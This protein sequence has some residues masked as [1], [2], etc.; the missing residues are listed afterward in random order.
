MEI[1]E[2]H[3]RRVPNAATS[4]V[5]ICRTGWGTNQNRNANGV[6]RARRNS[7]R[8]SPFHGHFFPYAIP[9]LCMGRQEGSKQARKGR[10]ERKQARKKERKKDR[11]GP[12][13]SALIQVPASDTS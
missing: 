11:R 8:K 12:G 13:V 5:R 6:C 4:P 2:S 7:A 1:P 9:L 3:P 10:Q